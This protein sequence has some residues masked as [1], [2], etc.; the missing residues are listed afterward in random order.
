MKLIHCADLHLD[1][2]M[3]HNLTPAQAKI[4]REELLRTY[5]GIVE[6]AAR[7]GA[8]AILISGDMFDKAHLK[9][10]VLNRVTEAI[11][12]HPDIDFLYLK[13][14]HDNLDFGMDSGDVPKPDNLKLFNADSWRE[15]RYGEVSVFGRELNDG[16]Y[17]NIATDLVLDVDRCNIVMLH[18]QESNYVG[19]DRTHII[20][21][22]DFRSKNI[23]YMA[24]GHI[25]KYK[26][27]RLDD[28]GLYCYPGCPEGRGFDE[29]GKK[30]FVELNIE[31]GHITTEF[32]ESAIREFHN[33]EVAV[34]ADWSM[35][36]IIAACD[37]ALSGIPSD[38]L[39]KLVLTG[40]REID[41]EID[42]ERIL[43]SFSDRFFFLKVYDRTK[44]RIDYESFVYDKTLKGEFVR[45][46]K[47]EELPEDEKARIVD[48]GIKAIMGEEL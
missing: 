18:G 22:S 11:E 7:V 20:N 40:E 8:R 12:A 30:G 25:H 21:M 38:D 3:E 6:H 27:D 43:Q 33:P 41:T 15:Y 23:D 14:N 44:I 9:K 48:L 13:G 36:D 16:N 32:I 2:K 45:L 34:A 46:L 37:E 31:D 1:S 4:R 35:R 24:L 39:V 19:K 17:R 5:E 26:C 10:S 29:C 47:E 28:R 42:T